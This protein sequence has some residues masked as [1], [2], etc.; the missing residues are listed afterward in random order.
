MISHSKIQFLNKSKNKRN[1]IFYK[2]I[3]KFSIDPVPYF[4]DKVGNTKYSFLYESVEKGKDKG[5]YTFCGYGTLS[6][7]TNKKNGLYVTENKKTKKIKKGRN[8]LN[9]INSI[10]SSYKIA[11]IQGLPPMTSSFFGYLSYENINNIENIISK[12]KTDILKIP[13]CLLFIPETLI[14]YDNQKSTL[15]LTKIINKKISN[16]KNIYQ[17]LI[18]EFEKITSTIKINNKYE[19]I[20]FKKRKK[21]TPRSNISKSKFIKNINISKKYIKDGDIF[22]VVPSHR[23][24]A[25]YNS[26]GKKLYQVLRKTNPSPF[27]YYF[28]LPNFNIVGSSPEILVRLRDDVITIRPIAGT[29]PRGRNKTQDRSYEQELLRDKKEISEHLMLLDLGRND[30]G[31]VAKKGSVKVTSSFA[32][33]KYSHVMHI[34]SNVQGIIKKGITSIDALMAGFPA[35]TVTGAPKIRAMQIIDE[36]EETKRGIYA[37]GIGYISP[38]GDMD[39]CIALRTGIIHKNKLYV[40]AGGGIVYDS[41]PQKEY[42]ET[43]NKAKAVFNAAEIALGN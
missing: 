43:V 23:F 22:Q 25:N 5:R 14:I 18:N 1:F 30:V 24:S 37:G 12:K 28:N 21:I 8:I 38:N 39:T 11:N 17:K 26:T 27:L 41:N 16:T 10:I 2:K 7:I 19:K 33:E 32:V 35:G 31:R 20:N 36:L 34:V 4:M 3:N 29:R 40:Q 13:D 9:Q 42:E 6:I 15:Y